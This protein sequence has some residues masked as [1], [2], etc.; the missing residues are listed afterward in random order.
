VKLSINRQR[1]LEDFKKKAARIY[2]LLAVVVPPMN[3]QHVVITQTHQKLH[4]SHG[5]IER[6]RSEY[7]EGNE[8]KFCLVTFFK[9]SLTGALKKRSKNVAHL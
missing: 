2:P 4:A 3:V 6:N 5:S 7:N 1:A 9:P 8:L